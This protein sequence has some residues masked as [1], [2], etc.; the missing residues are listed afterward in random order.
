LRN[1]FPSKSEYLKGTNE[2]F[3]WFQ[4]LAS[5]FCQEDKSIE[6]LNNVFHHSEIC[7]DFIRYLTN[8][9][10]IFTSQGYQGSNV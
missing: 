10:A 5:N 1:I 7:S 2:N 9:Y 8:F 6:H 3:R 4:T